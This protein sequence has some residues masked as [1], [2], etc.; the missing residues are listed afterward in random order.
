MLQRKRLNV[1]TFERASTMSTIEKL[2]I[3]SV[4]YQKFAEIPVSFTVYKNDKDKS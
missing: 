4:H 1:I 2:G 3:T